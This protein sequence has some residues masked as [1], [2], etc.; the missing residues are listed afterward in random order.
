MLRKSFVLLVMGAVI[1]LLCPVSSADVPDSINYQGKLTTAS[2]GC[3][4]D[5]VQM[6]FTI[7]TDESGTVSEWS[8]TQTAVEVKE[9]I[10]N[11]LLGS[12]NPLPA[13]I[14][15][16]AAK[17]LGVQVESDPEM[18]PLK[19]M[20][21][22]A[23]AYK[24][25]EADTADFA[26]S[27]EN[28]DLLDGQHASAFLSTANDY[29]RSGVATDLYEGT[30]TLTD[31]YVNVTGPDSVVSASGAALLGK[32]T[33]SSSAI[34]G[35]KG[36]GENTSTGV[37]YGG[38]FETPSSGTGTHYGIRASGSASSNANTYGVYGRAENS[39]DGDVCAGYF[40]AAASG[41]GTHYGVNARS[42]S[43]SSGWHYGVYGYASNSSTGYPKGG[44][45]QA[46]SDG[47]GG[48][49]G[50]WAEGY[51]TSSAHTY[52]IHAEASNSSSGRSVAAS[53]YTPPSYVGTGART[54]VDISVPDSSAGPTRGIHVL[55]SNR[56]TG[57]VYGGYF[58]SFGGATG[59]GTRYGVYA[60]AN[61]A[62]GWAGYFGG[63]VRITD[64]LVVLGG[65]S[66]AVKVDNGE[67]RLLY[68]QESPEVWF[69]DFGE[70]RLLNGSAV[71]QIDPLFA[72][73]VN[74]SVKYHVFLTPQD[75]PLTLA[76]A[77]KTTAT[78]EVIGPSSAN[79]PFSYRI[80]AKRKGYE[81]I[82]LAKMGKPTPEEV[83]WQ[84]ARHRAETEEEWAKLE[85]Q[86]QEM[87]RQREKMEAENKR[88]E[89]EREQR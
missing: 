39:S 76:V 66:A 55:A 80:V 9:G 85:E 29:G 7:Y 89:Q 32:A 18:T 86:R 20:V 75:E 77:N 13:S 62:Y 31:K 33:G 10:F 68:S 16:G 72:Q 54:G 64:S 25:N 67:Y 58:D 52:G 48:P 24:S 53:F 6:T 74:T 40:S 19:P 27:A 22:T 46:S 69:E 35:I 42:Y 63:D 26:W 65:K 60:S 11:V 56:S 28:A 45:F 41:T 4:N 37:A 43:S 87:K 36:Y 38:Y 34:Y 17:Y 14:F 30:S 50:V 81:D 3:V 71:I 15:D 44:F 79:V 82:R 12:V 49:V 1:F 59:T 21:T 23:Y 57:S 8:E 47:T 84:Q 70:G 51:G 83:A 88:M 61:A 2:G 73:T 5:T 78:F